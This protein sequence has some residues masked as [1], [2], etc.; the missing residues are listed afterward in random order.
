M[1]RRAHLRGWL[2]RCQ[3]EAFGALVLGNSAAWLLMSLGAYGRHTAL[4]FMLGV[5]G[6]VLPLIALS[7]LVALVPSPTPSE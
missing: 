7:A 4:A 6:L 1:S 5:D 2:A 3:P